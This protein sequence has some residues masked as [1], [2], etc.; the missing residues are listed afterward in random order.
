[1]VSKQVSESVTRKTN[2]IPITCSLDGRAHNVTDDS[3]VAGQHTGHYQALCGH[4]VSA[5]ALATPL[6]R[7]CAECTAVAAT[8]QQVPT[9]RPCRRA[10]H[11]QSGWLRRKLRPQRNTGTDMGGC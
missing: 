11:R 1:M 2:T 9:L 7:P 6:G 4:R 5:A 10:R 3:L 8:Q